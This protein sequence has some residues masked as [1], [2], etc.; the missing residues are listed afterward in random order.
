MGHIAIDVVIPVHDIEHRWVRLSEI[1]DSVKDLPIRLILVLDDVNPKF[2]TLVSQKCEAID[3]SK[4]TLINGNF[5]SAALSRNAGLKLC[6]ADW[7][8]FWDSDDLMFPQEY[9]KMQSLG[10]KLKSQIV[11]GQI[12]T[13]SAISGQVRTHPIKKTDGIQNSLLQIGLFPGF[14]RMIYRRETLSG[15]SFQPVTLG[16][17]QIFLASLFS[18]NPRFDIYD[19][20][21]YQYQIHQANQV[22][23]NF[24]SPKDQLR[25]VEILAEYHNTF[26]RSDSLPL[27]MALKLWTGLLKRFLKLDWKTR[28]DTIRLSKFFAIHSRDLTY[29]LF[30]IVKQKLGSKS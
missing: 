1:I 3:R 9:L 28:L 29:I 17:D 14:T 18:Q 12:T 25:S 22:T 7:I 23:K 8:A 19:E 20:V 11:I 13:R 2:L 26:K 30:F 4:Y 5:G 24:V 6:E 10:T 15:I 21:V 16:E 27:L